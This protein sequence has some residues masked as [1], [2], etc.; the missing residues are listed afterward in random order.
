MNIF[1]PQTIQS[2]VE[3]SMLANVTNLIISPRN[4]EPIIELRQDG[5]L[6]S[7]L[8]TESDQKL[9]WNR[10]MKT[11]M[12]TLNIDITNVEK[13]PS[14]T[15]E[16]MSYLIPNINLTTGKINV[17]NGEYKSGKVNQGILNNANGFLGTIYDQ[18]G[19]EKTRD[20]IDNLQKV[21]LSWL[22]K[23]GFS[24]GLKDC[25]VDNKILSDIKD[26]TNK[27]MIEIKHLITEQE[28]HPGLLDESIF[29]DNVGTMLS[30]HAGNM[31]KIVMDSINSSN[32]FFVMVDSGAKGKLEQLGSVSSLVG[33]TN[34]N[35]K[36]IAKKVNN[37]TLPHF[38]QFDDTP[39]ARGFISSSY[40]KG[41]RPTEFFF[42]QMAGRDG[43]IDTAIKTADTGY[44]QRKLIKGMEDVMITYDGLVRSA[45]NQILQY[46]Y[47]GSNLDQV[48]QKEVKIN[49][50]TLNNEK[51]RSTHVFS[52]SELTSMFKKSKGDN[53]K[54]NEEYY[55]KLIE[56]RDELRKIVVKC[57][58][59]Y[60]TFQDKFMLP[61]NLFRIINSNKDMKETK[62]DLE[63]IDI[64][65]TIEEIML[66]ENTKLFCMLD[67]ERKKESHKLRKEIEDVNKYLF[68]I[69]VYEY[70]S[71]RRC[72]MDYKFTKKILEKVKKEIISAFN[73]A[74]VDPGEMVGV[75]GAQS[76]G[77]RTT[78]LNLNTKHSA[79]AVKKGTQ[80]V[81]RMNEILRCTKNIK[82][83]I[84]TIYLEDEYKYDK[85]S[86]Y[87]IASYIGY[88]TLRDIVTKSDIGYDPDI[89]NGYIAM[90]K[91][92]AKTALQIYDVKLELKKLPWMFRFTI[93]REMLY[94]KKL[95]LTE[96][97]M[98]FV[99]FW[100]DKLNN[101]KNI[102][103]MEKDIFNRIVCCAIVSSNE[104][105]P[106][107][108]IHIRFEMNNY[109]INKM[110]EIQDYILS[111]FNL[112]G[113][114]G[115]SSIDVISQ[116]QFKIKEN[117]EIENHDQYI[118]QTDGIN[119]S[120]I[121]GI[122]GIDHVRTITNDM[123]S[124]YANFG[125]E[126]VRNALINEIS[127][128]ITNV[129]YHHIALLIDV[130][131]HAGGLISI[132]R[133][134][135][136]RQDTDPLSRA[137]FEKTMEQ[138]LNAAAFNETDKL[139]S[140]SSRIIIGRMINGGTGYCQLMMDN[141][142]L[143]NTELNVSSIEQGLNETDVVM[144]LEEN[145]VIDDL[146][147]KDSNI[148]IV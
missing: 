57:K 4:T 94:A 54:L 146:I 119:M 97:K 141:D 136:N 79:G 21:I 41:L 60:V 95:R 126:A 30:A 121:R 66:S 135:I 109:D 99:K 68:M 38:H 113:L 42:H 86:A 33:Q 69:S 140:V 25:I 125:V 59:N 117:G 115:V 40:I 35:N 13:S 67:A 16:L 32:N 49:L 83:P 75:L 47:G 5:V 104:N 116:S 103:K 50:I 77:E 145:A 133:H 44:V 102:S 76:M 7:Y 78:Q 129:N 53:N 56:F 87:K 98:N 37:R 19:G 65:E 89:Q 39:T 11:L 20:F 124:I 55:N 43:L 120:G 106:N 61:V 12:N 93:N 142:I 147:E 24:V 92:D 52:K 51:V 82:T 70:L 110:I 64:I 45:N 112:K 72:I 84:L 143:E 2:V 96:I 134:G 22:H 26:K 111:Y 31:G 6:G 88:L 108:V 18:Y 80:G 29:E 137:S 74:I 1:V 9:T 8:F 127:E 63:I 138:F 132:D 101:T 46:F 36:R 144:K 73:K 48:K 15:Y 123:Y 58:S 85:E 90:D 128:L 28:N 10:V 122:K 71:P 3:L 91:I 17:E 62:S 118:L 34:M 105:D 130:M 81:T 107:A 148:F 27:L 100:R 14:S 131:T 23:K 139:K 114:D